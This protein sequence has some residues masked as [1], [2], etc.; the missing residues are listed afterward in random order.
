MEYRNDR[1]EPQEEQETRRDVRIRNIEW[2]RGTAQY[3]WRTFF[4]MKLD[5]EFDWD[6]VSQAKRKIYNICHHLYMS[7]FVRS[8]RDIL[9]MYFT[10]KWGDDMNDVAEY[11]EKNRVS[12]RVIWMVVRRASRLAMEE[13]GLLEKRGEISDEQRKE[14]KTRHHSDAL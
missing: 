13:T 2:W 8:D 7:R 12:V 6:H 4:A 14:S 5:P 1:D 9:Q 3:M 11:S 10:S